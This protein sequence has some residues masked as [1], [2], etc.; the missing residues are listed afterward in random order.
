[1]KKLIT[2]LLFLVVSIGIY[3]QNDTIE[4]NKSN[5]KG[6]VEEQ[7]I[8]KN[9]KSYTLT[10]I[11]YENTLYKSNKSTKHMFELAKEN[12]AEIKI[13]AIRKDGKIKR[14]TTLF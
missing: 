7:R 10:Y 12:N 2:I 5:I 8:S 4:I 13:Y 3:S 11:V 14:I 6:F 1:M 9:G